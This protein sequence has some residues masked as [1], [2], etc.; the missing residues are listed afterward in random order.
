MSDLLDRIRRELQQRLEATSAAAQEHERVRAALEAL[1]HAV[2][3]L[4]RV[5]RRAAGGGTQANRGSAARGSS[6]RI[7]ARTDFGDLHFNTPPQS[8]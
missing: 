5:A 1:G 6:G 8:S 4:E 7:D 2:A 3:P